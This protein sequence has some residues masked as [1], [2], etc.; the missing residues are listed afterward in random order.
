MSLGG[1]Q[2]GFSARKVPRSEVRWGQFLICNHG[3]E[4]VIQLISHVSGEV[5]FELCKIEAERMAHVLLEAS[6]AERS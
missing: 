4:E 5:E 1:F 6:R 2:S 3:C